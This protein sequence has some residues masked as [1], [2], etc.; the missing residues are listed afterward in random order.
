MLNLRTAFVL[1]CVAAAGNVGNGADWP[2]WMGP[3]RNGIWNEKGVVRSI[4]ED[5]LPVKWRLPIAGGYAGPA[6]ADGK[7]YVCDY[8][9]TSGDVQ[10]NAGAAD[11]RTGKE[12]VLCV[13]SRTGEIVWSH[14]YDCNYEVSYGTGRG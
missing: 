8:V 4:P 9:A 6:V 3:E 5:G 10:Y 1:A 12:R 13:D 7:V 2:Q 14:E 11:K